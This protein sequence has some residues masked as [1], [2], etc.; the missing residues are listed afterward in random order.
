[1]K[2]Y[3]QYDTRWNAQLNIANTGGKIMIMGANI[4]VLLKLT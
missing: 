1:M 3:S 4:T 2:Y